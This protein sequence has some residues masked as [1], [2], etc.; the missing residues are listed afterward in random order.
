MKQL[1]ITICS[2][3]FPPVVGGIAQWAKGIADGLSEQNTKVNVHCRHFDNYPPEFEKDFG[4][5]VSY[6]K[7]K[8]WKRKR[9]FYWKSILS[10]QIASG[11]VPDF[12]IATTWNASRGLTGIC[13]RNGIKL[14]TIAHGLEVTRK[15]PFLKKIWL[16]YTFNQCFKVIAVSE[17]TRKKIAE[18]FGTPSS[19]LAV[20][21]NGV[22]YNY[23]KPDNN[24]AYL[25]ERYGLDG[26]KIIMTLARVNPRKGHDVVIKAISKIK[27]N[28][29]EVVYL[30]SGPYNENY[31]SELK[32]QVS[33]L[34]LE[35]HVYFS[36]YVENSEMVD[37]Y[38]LCDIYV[39]Q[40][41]YLDGDSEGFGITFL[42]ANACEKPVIGGNSG[43]VPDAIEEGYSGFL[44]ES[45]DAETLSHKLLYL[46]N[47]EDKA[48]QMG[49]NGRKRVI[50]TY[51]WSAISKQLLD[52]IK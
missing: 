52:I 13:K 6:H 37:H 51:N 42:E 33:D 1:K 17:F 25:R 11:D 19:K 3:D 30:V 44:V 50:K 41:R 43:G 26:K 38:N 35:D 14:I 5:R 27:D 16:R 20:L 2:E 10:E 40:S 29:G 15:M 46:L 4:Y 36:G 32:Q 18:N 12:C 39:M 34:G 24:T 7:R 49:K 22:D 31:M 48:V 45:E 21:P 23:F 8:D 47:N 28:L 9:T